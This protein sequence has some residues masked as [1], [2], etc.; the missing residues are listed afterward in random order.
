MNPLSVFIILSKESYIYTFVEG[1]FPVLKM[2]M[3]FIDELNIL[4]SLLSYSKITYFLS[5][6]CISFK[7]SNFIVV[8]EL[9]FVVEIPIR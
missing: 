7:S 2:K 1:L 3:K 4:C 5:E 8:N 6:N 9:S